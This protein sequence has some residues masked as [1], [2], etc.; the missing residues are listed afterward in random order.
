MYKLIEEWFQ[1]EIN[2]IYKGYKNMIRKEKTMKLSKKLSVSLVVVL[3]VMTTLMM[4]A[5]ANEKVTAEETTTIQT[6][7]IQPRI[8]VTVYHEEWVY[9]TVGDYI[10]TEIYREGWYGGAYVSGWL[11]LSRTVTTGN[12]IA[13]LYAGNLVGS[14]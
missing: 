4:P 11:K 14:A 10:P 6:G 2:N 13:V 5:F 7:E 3:L 9:Y 8:A 1:W 12:S